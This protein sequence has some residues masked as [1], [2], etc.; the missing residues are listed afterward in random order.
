MSDQIKVSQIKP[1]AG[2]VLVKPADAQKQTA[3]GIYLPDSSEEKPQHG[4]VVA[5]GEKVFQEGKELLPPVKAK[6]VVLYKK[7][8]GNDIKLNDIEYQILKFEDILAT[9]NNTK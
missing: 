1:L 7:W 9:I 2:Y 8:G 3:S 5:V 6:D 4:V